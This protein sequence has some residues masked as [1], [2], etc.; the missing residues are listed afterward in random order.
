[1]L[2]LQPPACG[3]S[4]SA[5]ALSTYEKTARRD[6]AKRPNIP[7]RTSGYDFGGAVDAALAAGE[8]AGEA[9]AGVVAGDDA[10]D[11]CGPTGAGE[12]SAGC[13]F[14]SSRRKALLAMLWCA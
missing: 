13:V 6:V 10:G 14:I 8:T 11:V 7:Q 3:R 2:R 9:L 1:M 5:P 4:I 12:V